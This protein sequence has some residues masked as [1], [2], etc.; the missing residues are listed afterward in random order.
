M[1]TLFSQAGLKHYNEAVKQCIC[2]IDGNIPSESDL[3][4]PPESSVEKG[5]KRPKQAAIEER[6]KTLNIQLL[7]PEVRRSFNGPN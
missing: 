1:S 5:K 3:L 2:V 7:I 4:V 6:M